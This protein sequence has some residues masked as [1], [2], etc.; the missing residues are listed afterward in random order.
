MLQ[1][2]L[3]II[4]ALCFTSSWAVSMNACKGTAELPALVIINDLPSSIDGK[5][6]RYTIGTPEEINYLASCKHVPETVEIRPGDYVSADSDAP[7]YSVTIRI[8]AS[9][10]VTNEH[11]SI[12]AT[13]DKINCERLDGVKCRR[14]VVKNKNNEVESWEWHIAKSVG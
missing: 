5:A 1:F 10:H 4:L 8:Q 13:K 11:W 2:L 3:C 6:Y 7:T 9:D 12:E 14:V